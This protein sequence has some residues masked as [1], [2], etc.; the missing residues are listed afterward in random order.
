MKYG[1]R[2]SIFGEV[3]ADNVKRARQIVEECIVPNLEDIGQTLIIS[4]IDEN[5]WIKENEFS[6]VK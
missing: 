1:F 3:E 4:G 2:V 6:P 5:E